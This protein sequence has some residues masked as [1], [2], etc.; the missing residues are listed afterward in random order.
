M[1]YL[2]AVTPGPDP[3]R[4]LI[5]DD[6]ELFATSLQLALDAQE[7]IVVV[8]VAHDA[9]DAIDL[10]VASDPDVV[11]MDVGLPSF[12]GFEATKRLLAIKQLTKVIGVSG[13]DFERDDLRAADAGMV[14]LLSKDHIVDT[15]V[16]AIRS[17]GR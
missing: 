10:A 9:P 8:G 12:D 6:H 2:S 5:V 3:V 1:S 7:G 17:A 14:A 11:L 16:D 4:V 15:V 13:Y